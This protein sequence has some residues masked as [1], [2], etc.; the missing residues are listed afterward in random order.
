MRIDGA[1]LRTERERKILSH[2]ELA[3]AARLSRTTV[4]KLENNEI[5]RPHP[6]TVRKLAAALDVDPRYILEG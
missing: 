3:Q 6:K 4:I 5:E 2:R 1:K